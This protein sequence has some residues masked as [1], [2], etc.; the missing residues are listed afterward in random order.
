[1]CI[2]TAKPAG[3]PA[4]DL[5]ALRAMWDANPDGAGV[6]FA[7]HGRVH[8]RKG[9]MTWAAFSDAWDALRDRY[10]L[11]RLPVVLHFRIR[12]HG[13]LAPECC[14]PFPVSTSLGA[15]RKLRAV[16]PVG[17][18]HNGVIPGG[19][20]DAGASDTMEFIT[21]VLAPLGRAMP[22]WY[23]DRN[24]AAAV[25][26]VAQSRLCI[27]DGS[28]RIVRLGTGWTCD[29]GIW[30]S[31]TSYAR[32]AW[33]ADVDTDDARALMWLPTGS[34]VQWAGDLYDG[35]EFLVDPDGAV[36]AYVWDLDAV[37]P[38]PGAVA[39]TAEGG[40]VR[41]SAAGVLDKLRIL[42]EGGCG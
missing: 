42:G 25:E 17:V 23:M 12:T 26:A 36:Y 37:E 16:G 18:A 14:H 24:A 15:L 11:D 9:Y 6:M 27:L 40:P 3:T 7:V 30:Y 5:A 29:G 8:I 38:A 13:A 20:G 31:N 28:G 32:G 35:E 41:W 4:W 10:D 21:R 19:W 1:M 34:S 33:Y 2:I 39:R 22:R